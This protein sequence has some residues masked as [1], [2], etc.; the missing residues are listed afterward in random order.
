MKHRAARPAFTETDNPVTR[1]GGGSPARLADAADVDVAR[2]SSRRNDL[3]DQLA[4]PGVGIEQAL[5]IAPAA[6]DSGLDARWST[7]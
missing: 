6:E 7:R 2:H 4:E 3:A 1:D 5:A